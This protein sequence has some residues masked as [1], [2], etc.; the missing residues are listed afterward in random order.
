MEGVRHQGLDE[1]QTVFVAVELDSKKSSLVVSVATRDAKGTDAG[2]FGSTGGACGVGETTVDDSRDG[3]GNKG[4]IG[5]V[6]AVGGQENDGFFHVEMTA[7]E[8]SVCLKKVYGKLQVARGKQAGDVVQVG[9][10]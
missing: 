2:E 10:K 9:E 6:D 8:G 5:G 4:R 1:G 3:G 7:M